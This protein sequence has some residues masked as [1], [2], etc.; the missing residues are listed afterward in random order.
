MKTKLKHKQKNQ[1]K[2]LNR[3]K[4]QFKELIQ[5]FLTDGELLVSLIKMSEKEL[6]KIFC[7]TSNIPKSALQNLSKGEL[8]EYAL[9]MLD[10]CVA[11]ESELDG[12]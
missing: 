4:N 8:V 1:F 6:V 7:L 12:G 9:D 2:E 5:P 10:F 3:Q 11:H